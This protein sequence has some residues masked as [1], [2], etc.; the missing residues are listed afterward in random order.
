MK[1]VQSIRNSISEYWHGHG[2]P[3]SPLFGTNEDAFAAYYTSMYLIQDTSESVSIHMAND[4]STDP[5]K[6]YIE[7]WGVMQALVIQQDAICEIHDAVLGRQPAV[8]K[9]S[10]W[11]ELRDLRNRCAGHPANKA[12]SGSTVRSFMG[13]NFGDYD[14]LTY[15]QYDAGSKTTTHP[16]VKLRKLIHDYDAQAGAILADVFAEMKRKCP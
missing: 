1:Q 10:P 8:Q 7:F 13:R 6:A 4:F 14:K 16:K 15:E 12:S 11:F 3:V 9:P 2:F 5:F